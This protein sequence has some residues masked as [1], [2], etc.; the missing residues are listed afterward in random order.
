MYSPKRIVLLCVHRR[1]AAPKTSKKHH[2]KVLEWS[3]GLRMSKTQIH[4]KQEGL[5]TELSLKVI[6]RS[7]RLIPIYTR[8]VATENRRAL[9]LY[10]SRDPEGIAIKIIQSISTKLKIVKY[11]YIVYRTRF[12]KRSSSKIIIQRQSNQGPK[13]ET[14]GERGHNHRIISS[15]VISSPLLL[16]QRSRAAQIK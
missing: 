9:H 1:N 3:L 12:H 6:T 15:E 7:I 4:R 5:S 14:K 8:L 16:E 11:G 13:G 2:D 10:R